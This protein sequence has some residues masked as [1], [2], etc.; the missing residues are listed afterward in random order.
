MTAGHNALRG[1]SP[2]QFPALD[3]A[4]ALVGFPDHRID[5]ICITCCLSFPTFTSRRL[6]ARSRLCRQRDGLPVA[7]ALAHYRPRHTGELVGK[8][9]RGHFGWPPR[10]QRG[11]P[12]PVFGAVDL[13]VANDRQ[14]AR[15]E[16]TA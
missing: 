13:G 5:R 2:G 1:S 15:C 9:D 10:Q 11:E 7:L 12:W 4:V 8:R 6:T 14:R 3:R 16:Q